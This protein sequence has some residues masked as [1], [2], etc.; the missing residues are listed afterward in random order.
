MLKRYQVL[1][2]DWLEDNIKL[3]AER[4]DLSFSE[5]IR[6]EICVAILSAVPKVYP[7]YKPDLT[8]EE[9]MKKLLGKNADKMEREE[10]HRW[11]SKIY[12]E[13][14][15]AVEYRMSKEKKKRKK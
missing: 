5:V 2:P 11:L 6:A 7:E 3:F 8:H 14:R 13:A 15:K 1:L 4:Y 10:V 12:F 9:I